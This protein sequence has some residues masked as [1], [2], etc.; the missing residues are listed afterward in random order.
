MQINNFMFSIKGEIRKN[1]LS[2]YMKCYN[3]PML[4]RK[5]FLNIANKRIYIINHCNRPLLKF[6]RLLR[7][8]YLNENPDGNETRVFD[9][10]LK[11][12]YNVFG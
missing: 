7:E 2:T 9:D 12:Y 1:V 6:D 5:F 11:N 4:W 10:N 3:I 8:W